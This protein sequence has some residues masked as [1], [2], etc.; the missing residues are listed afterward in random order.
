MIIEWI[1]LDRLEQ[2]VLEAD[3]TRL[4][5]ISGMLGFEVFEA[6]VGVAVFRIYSK[7]M[8]IQ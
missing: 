5:G 8:L 1:H 2:E 4:C 6:H 7:L 3:G